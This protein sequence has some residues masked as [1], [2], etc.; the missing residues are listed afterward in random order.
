MFWGTLTIFRFV[1]AHIK[2]TCSRKLNYLINLVFVFSIICFILNEMGNYLLTL[3][4]GSLGFG[5]ACSAI[6]SLLV[7]VPA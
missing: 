2:I 7:S 3:V 5:V 1:A 4:L 6:F